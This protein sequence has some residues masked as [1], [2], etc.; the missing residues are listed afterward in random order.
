[1]DSALLKQGYQLEPTKYSPPLGSSRIRV[2]ISDQPAQ[3]FFD[4]K[5]LRLPTFDG[6]YYHQ[7]QITR[8]ELAPEA[9]FQVCLGKFSLESYHGDVIHG[10]SFGGVLETTLVD[11]DLYCDLTSNAPI[12][13]LRDSP[14][15]MGNLLADELIDLLAENEARLAGHEEE[16]YSRL[17]KFE[18][19]KV[20]LSCM[21]TLQKRFD[22][23]PTSLR[24]DKFRKTNAVLQKII[25]I[26]RDTDG[27]DG[28]SPTLDELLSGPG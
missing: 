1:M 16:L 27:W 5:L 28:R 13:T 3:R 8:H 26:V 6:R 19:Y 4:V 24:R 23:V 9:T 15:V 21:V 20:F 25:H 7:T 11:K 12:F 2:V 17:A 10:F 18:P 22:S 14:E